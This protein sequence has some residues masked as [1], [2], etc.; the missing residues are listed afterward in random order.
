MGGPVVQPTTQSNGLGDPT[1]M[2]VF[3]LPAGFARLAEY[4]RNHTEELK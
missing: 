3:G 1:E 2:R 4:S